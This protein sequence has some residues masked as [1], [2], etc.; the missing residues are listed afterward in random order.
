MKHWVPNWPDL[1][2]L[3]GV[4]LDGVSPLGNLDIKVVAHWGL[5]LLTYCKENHN[6][7]TRSFKWS[8]TLVQ[9][10]QQPNPKVETKPR[11]KLVGKNPTET[12]SISLVNQSI[13]KYFLMTW[14]TDLA[15]VNLPISIIFLCVQVCVIATDFF[16]NVF[17]KKWF[18]FFF[19]PN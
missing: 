14:I 8:V 19:Y 13:S 7:K 4:P 1:S 16:S 6:A 2:V 3:V 17:V 18:I 5:D 9:L 11:K 12:E 15:M 10:W